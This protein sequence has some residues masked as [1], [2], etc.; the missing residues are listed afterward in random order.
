MPFAFMDL[1]ADT[2]PLMLAEIDDDIG[3]DKLYLSNRLSA[4]GRDVYPALLREAALFFDESWLAEKLRSRNCFSPTY[5]RR[6]PAGG[7]SDARMPA[8]AADTLAE[9]EFNRFYM[10][11]LCRRAIRDGVAGLAVY[12][13]KTV[14]DPRPES[15]AKIGQLIS[16]QTLLDDLRQNIGIDTSL[17]LPAG[18]SSGLCVKL[19]HSATRASRNVAGAS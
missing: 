8:N 16:P 2:R 9:G 1:D 10:R 18:P 12:R 11:G 15:E 14:K 3:A 19:V 4:F 17:G 5:Q 6:N 13:A 7:F